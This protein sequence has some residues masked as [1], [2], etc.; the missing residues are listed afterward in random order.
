[1]KPGLIV[2]VVLMLIGGF[3]IMTG[4]SADEPTGEL[5]GSANSKFFVILG[6]IG[7]FGGIAVA[8]EMLTRKRRDEQR[9]ARRAQGEAA[10][11]SSV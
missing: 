6:G 4:L 3:L 5:S 8:A 1:M 7:I 2:P 10:D 11:S 9:I